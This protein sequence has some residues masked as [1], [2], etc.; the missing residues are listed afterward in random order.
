MVNDNNDDILIWDPETGALNFEELV[1]LHKE[2]PEKL[3]QLQQRLVRE[4]IESV[5][6]R[7]QKRL[8][9]L[10]FEIDAKRQMAK[11]PMHSF[12]LLSEMFWEKGFCRLK[13]ALNGKLEQPDTDDNSCQILSFTDET[14]D[15]TH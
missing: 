1:R 9:G 11:D 15:T 3:E 8:E 10:Q 14:T 4:L 13:D 2:D 12:K 5:P 7:S 6:E